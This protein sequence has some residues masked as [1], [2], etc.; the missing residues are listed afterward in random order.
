[1]IN[2]QEELEVEYKRCV[3]DIVDFATHSSRLFYREMAFRY[4]ILL[5]LNRCEILNHIQ[6]GYEEHH[7][8]E[9]I[10]ETISAANQELM[11]PLFQQGKEQSEKK[12][13]CQVKPQSEVSEGDS[14]KQLHERET[15]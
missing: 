2:A 9:N 1:M 13:V 11:L 4:W 15:G 10:Y 3:Q 7:G 12:D 8:E 5:V 6:K 14:V